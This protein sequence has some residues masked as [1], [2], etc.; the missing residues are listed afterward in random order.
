VGDRDRKGRGSTTQREV[1]QWYQRFWPHATP[2]GA[3]AAGRDILNVPLDI[4]VKARRGFNP[5]EWVRQ[6]RKRPVLETDK[7]PR[8]VVM[9][10]DGLGEAH[11]SEWLVF[12]T[13]E[14]DTA[15]LAELLY[16][17]ACVASPS[18]TPTCYQA[19]MGF[20]VHGPYCT[21]DLER[22]VEVIE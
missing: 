22:H 3:G 10:P 11:V 6:Q 1:A 13:L 21:C 8:Q 17:R 12:R 4:E 18:E 14:D 20:M 2:A 7:L 5:L 9:R 15:I 19:A 16:L